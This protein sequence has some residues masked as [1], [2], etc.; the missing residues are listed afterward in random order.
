MIAIRNL[1]NTHT[2]QTA[3]TSFTWKSCQWLIRENF[4]CTLLI[5]IDGA[6][7]KEFVPMAFCFHLLAHAMFTLGHQTDIRFCLI[8]NFNNAS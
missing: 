4:K 3:L 1:S 8:T 2:Y 5:T 7:S 6:R